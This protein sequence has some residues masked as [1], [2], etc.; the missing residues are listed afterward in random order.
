MWENEGSNTFS[1]STTSDWPHYANTLLRL[2]EKKIEGGGLKKEGS[3]WKCRCRS[4]MEVLTWKEI[5]ACQ[6]ILESFQLIQKKH[7]RNIN[8]D[9]YIHN[10]SVYTH[11]DAFTC[12]EIQH[13]YPLTPTS[14]YDIYKCIYIQMR[15]FPVVI[16]TWQDCWYL[17]VYLMHF[18]PLYFCNYYKLA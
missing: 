4:E 17:S 18:F 12:M 2:K 1:G 16:I 11:V 8:S 10:I 14:L 13:A 15:L 9:S 5:R 6:L 7:V 3:E